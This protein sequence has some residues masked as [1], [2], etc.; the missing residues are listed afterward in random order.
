MTIFLSVSP[1]SLSVVTMSS[2]KPIGVGRVNRWTRK[3]TEQ[4]RE[5]FYFE[6]PAFSR[7]NIDLLTICRRTAESHTL[8]QISTLTRP[9]LRAL[10]QMPSSRKTASAMEV[11]EKVPDQSHHSCRLP[12]D[13][14]PGQPQCIS[15]P[16]P[17]HTHSRHPGHRT[18]RA[19]IPPHHNSLHMNF[20]RSNTVP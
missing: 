7:H 8:I 16:R 10:F 11:T 19:H 12:R 17:T 3:A 18:P 9:L 1:L 14:G 15:A 5:N 20:V 2:S 6:A 13:N 4:R